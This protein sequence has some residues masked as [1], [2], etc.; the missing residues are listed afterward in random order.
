MN[1]GELLGQAAIKV[2][3]SMGNTRSLGKCALAVG[4]ALSMVV[5][6]AEACKYRGNAYT[7]LPK[8]KTYN[9]FCYKGKQAP[10]LNQLPI[11]AIVVWDKQSAHPYGHIEIADGK[12]NLCSDFIRDARYQLYY[13]NPANIIPDIFYPT[14]VVLPSQDAPELDKPAAASNIIKLPYNVKVTASALYIRKG[15]D[16]SSGAVKLAKQ[17]D[18]LQVWAEE[19]KP[20]GKWGKNA[21][22]FF[23]LKYTEKI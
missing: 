14:E 17:G 10:P 3:K 4:D 5:S 9:R 8:L 11:G 16:V 6:E 12:G 23:A 13:S 22:G 21:T 20:D 19:T 2:A 15:S 1:F 18:I 7:W